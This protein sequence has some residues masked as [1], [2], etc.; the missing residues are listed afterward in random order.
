MNNIYRFIVPNS[1]KLKEFI[2]EK[3]MV[4]N[5]GDCVIIDDINYRVLKVDNVYNYDRL[6]KTHIIYLDNIDE[7]K[8]H[9]VF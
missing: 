8:L 2:M 4:P 7:V 3:N 6:N 5:V 9:L 1:K